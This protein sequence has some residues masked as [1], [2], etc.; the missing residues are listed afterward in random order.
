MAL[1]G[2]GGVAFLGGSG[3]LVADVGPAF[4][5]LDARASAGQSF[6]AGCAALKIG[7][8]AWIRTRTR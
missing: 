6:N 5:P 2:M 3:W 8:P 1:R 7:C 4:A